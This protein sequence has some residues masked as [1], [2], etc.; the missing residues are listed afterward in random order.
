VT[1]PPLG[2][3]SNDGRH[4]NDPPRVP[5]YS[6]LA[7]PNGISHLAIC[8]LSGFETK[9]VGGRAAPMWM[10]HFLDEVEALFFAVLPVGWVG[11]WHESP[12]PQWVV[13]LSGRW[14]IEA[15]DGSRVEMGPG[16][17]HWGQDINTRP[18][19]GNQGHRSGQIGTEPCVHLMVQFKAVH[20]ATSFRPGNG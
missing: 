19:G 2:V 13:P 15:Q 16:D 8:A 5:Y 20:G 17:I 9:S 11:E 10:R 3:P 12:K 7:E 6:L 1:L 14:F 18:V 4:E